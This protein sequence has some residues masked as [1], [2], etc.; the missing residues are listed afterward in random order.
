MSIPDDWPF[1][2]VILPVRN[3]D[4]HI[5]STLAALLAG[6]YPP[7]RL[8]VLVIDG[9]S[10]DATR[11]LAQ[12]V[13]AR[14]SRVRVLDNPAGRTPVGL[15]LGLAAARGAVIV[16]MDGHTLPA[17]DY[18]RA[19]VQALDRSGAWAVGGRMVGRG[20]TSFG[21]AVAAATASRFGAGDARYRIGGRGPVDTVYL[22]AW[23]REVF[24]RVGGFDP[25]L[26]RNQDYELCLRIRA[27]G[28]TVWLD[29]AIRSTT[30]VRGAPG[31]LARQYFGY[32][33]GR[34]ATWRRH[35]RS[36]RWRQALPALFALA[37]ALGLAGAP[38]SRTAR[39]FVALAGGSYALANLIASASV[40][41]RLAGRDALW[42]PLVYGI[43]HGAWGVG[44]WVG[45]T[46]RIDKRIHG[47]SG[48]DRLGRS[49][50]GAE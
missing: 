37:L 38:W 44:F 2:S 30:R 29:P 24:R 47:L 10:T 49:G 41:R 43:V 20:E 40:G 34:A 21:R 18:V 7:D 1:V 22:G 27:A 31:A 39:R 36:L 33:M 6:D 35:P 14:D 13:A 5:Q 19:C 4:R 15:N 32:G 23:R 17:A 50:G 8:E 46:Q 11:A 16:R 12:A 25:A 28:G 48:L 9:A 3:E 45:F 42:L 26:A